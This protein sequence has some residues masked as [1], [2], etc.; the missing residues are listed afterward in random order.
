MVHPRARGHVFGNLYL[1]EKSDGPDFTVEDEEA[2]ITLATQAGIAIANARLHEE[3]RLRERWLQAVRDTT[4]AII[5]GSEADDVLRRV[6]R[7]AR[8]LANADSATV[9]TPDSGDVMRLP[10]AEAAHPEKPEGLPVPMA[11]AV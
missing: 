3:V 7:S 2:L 6:A 1:T 8:D 5:A 4:A 9:A 10:I 11:G